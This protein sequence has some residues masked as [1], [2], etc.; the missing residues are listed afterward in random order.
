[1]NMLANMFNMLA[2]GNYLAQFYQ[3]FGKLWKDRNKNV[4]ENVSFKA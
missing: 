1:M 3:S 4:H 2:R